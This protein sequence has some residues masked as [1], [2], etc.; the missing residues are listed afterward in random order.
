M[1][2]NKQIMKPIS[3][4]IHIPFCIKKCNYCD[5]LSAPADDCV[6]E[7]Y[8]HALLEE[9][10]T[11]AEN[12][13]AYMVQTVFIGGGTPSAVKPEAI[14]E[15]L[16]TVRSCYLLAD[17]AEISMEANPGTLT[18]EALFLYRKAGV[19]RLSLGLQSADDAELKRLG[20]IHSYADFLE[21]YSL[22]REAG[23]TNM[24]VDL[25][26]ALPGQKPADYE[27]SLKKVLKLAPRPEHISAYSL[28]IEEGTPFYTL[29][30]REREE[31]AHTGRAQAHLPSEEEEWQMQLLTEE[32][33]ADAGYGRYEISN[34]SLPGYECR[35]NMV[36]WQRGDYVGF[37]LGAAS[38]VENIRFANVRDMRVYLQEKDKR[39][40]ESLLS[41][42]EQMEEFMFLGLRL[43]KGVEKKAF[44][45]SFGVSVEEVYGKII[46]K[47]VEEGLLVDGDFLALTKKG[48]YVSNYIM[49][50]FLLEE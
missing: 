28:I 14:G 30:G 47:A 46:K 12:Y 20:R 36:Y 34:Y 32:L 35:H 50:Q 16:K 29:Y 3:I 41:Q 15:M 25:M 23:F 24:N 22:A 39:A 19:N 48:L 43:I 5:F 44:Q 1:I 42:K 33:L 37:G 40:E 17:N 10:K 49:A 31:L 11:E 26:A 6:Q 38:M 45:K 21:S 4:Y 18:K 2:E 27:A 13:K 7:E 9:I 8:L